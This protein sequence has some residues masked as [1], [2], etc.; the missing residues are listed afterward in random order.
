MTGQ[1]RPA[2][3]AP[4][5]AGFSLIVSARALNVDAPILSSL[6]QLGMRPQ[7]MVTGGRVFVTGS[8]TVVII[9]RVGAIFHDG[10]MF[11]TANWSSNFIRILI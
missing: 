6:A 4:R 2:F 9:C 10:A 3:Q 11:G 5:K 7:R 1:R 8:R